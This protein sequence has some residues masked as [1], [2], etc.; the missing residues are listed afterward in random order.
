MDLIQE[1]ETDMFVKTQDSK[2]PS[3]H[4]GIRIHA[5]KELE[6]DDGL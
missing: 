5:V 1:G 2:S 6:Q 3:V 4:F